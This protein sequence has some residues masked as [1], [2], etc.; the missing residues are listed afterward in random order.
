MHK[1]AAVVAVP[2]LEDLHYFVHQTLC[3][4]DHLEPAHAPL[5]Q[6]LVRRAGQPCGLMFH[7][8]GPRLLKTYAIWA[9]EES[10][11]IFYD[12]TGERFAEVRLSEAPDPRQLAA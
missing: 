11:I 3:R 9:G 12:S 5:R 8:E 6:S 2:T 7:V 10:R 1:P 4:R